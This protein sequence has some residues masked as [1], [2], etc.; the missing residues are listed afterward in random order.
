LLN[1]KP[2]AF[3]KVLFQP[4][5]FRILKQLFSGLKTPS[6][7]VERYRRRT[8]FQI[9]DYAMK[10]MVQPSEAGDLGG[11]IRRWKSPKEPAAKW[12]GQGYLRRE[13]EDLLKQL[14][15]EGRTLKFDFRIQ[16]YQN[17]EKTSMENASKEWE[18]RDAPF[19]TVAQLEIPNPNLEDDDRAKLYDEIE[20]MAFSPWNTKNFKPLGSMNE[21]RRIVYDKSAEK[22]VG[23]PLRIGR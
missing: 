3:F 10:F 23:C 11:V 14:Q 7:A 9:G 8:P 18:E 16:L 1:A 21:A 4:E 15:Q 6:V 17:E 20:K 13:F 5:R 2:I 22:R 12:G 19:A